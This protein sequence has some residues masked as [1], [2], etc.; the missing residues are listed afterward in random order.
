MLDT[1]T[2]KNWQVQFSVKGED[3]MFASPINRYAL[4]YPTDESN[5]KNRFQIFPTQN[6]WNFIM[7]DSYACRI[8]Q[9]QYSTRDFDSQMCIPINETEQSYNNQSVYYIQPMTSM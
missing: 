3:Y 7:I 1:Y 8:W 6:M 9:V 5:W 2:E 4:S